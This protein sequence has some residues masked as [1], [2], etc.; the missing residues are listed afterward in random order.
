MQYKIEN[1]YV[2]NTK[3]E[4]LSGNDLLTHRETFDVDFQGRK[5]KITYCHKKMGHGTK[6]LNYSTDFSPYST[7]F[8]EFLNVN[9]RFF[10]PDSIAIDIGAYDGDTTLPISFLAGEKGLTFAF[11]P[12]PSF[13]SQ[14]NINLGY[15]PQFQ[16][17]GCPYAL[18]PEEGIHEFRYCLND[19]NGGAPQ[20][21]S[22]V[23]TY[24]VPRLVRAVNFYNFFKNTINFKDISF[25]KADCEGHD[26]HIFWSFKEMIK[27]VRPVLHAEWFPRT[28]GYIKQLLDYL[29]YSLYCGFSLEKLTLGVSPWRQD[30]V[31]V[32]T[33]KAETFN[34]QA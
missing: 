31:L 4:V 10:R 34:L 12:S 7:F 30:I 15:N 3:I 11:E 13:S 19:D 9:A 16:I 6:N 18:M 27:D 22:W 25:I 2:S 21:N 14:L 23:G 5:T 1:N 32:P 8:N 17:I 26:F 29:G 20:T 24:T 33:E 28:D